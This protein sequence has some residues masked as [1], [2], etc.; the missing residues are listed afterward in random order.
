MKWSSFA[1]RE[2][3]SPASLRRVP[4]GDASSALNAR[5]TSTVCAKAFHRICSSISRT[6]WRSWYGEVSRCSSATQS[7]RPLSFHPASNACGCS[8]FSR[9]ISCFA[10]DATSRHSFVRFAHCIRRP[11][12]VGTTT[13]HGM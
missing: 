7:F 8:A 11:P 6:S 13:F 1:W 3:W 5:S 4:P 10:T 12:H 2:R 9:S